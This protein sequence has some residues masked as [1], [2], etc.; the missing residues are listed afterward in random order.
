MKKP[1]NL[2]AGDKFR[3]IEE[4]TGFNVGEIVSLKEDD[5]SDWPY[6]WKADKSDYHCIFFSQLEPHTKTIRDAQ[7]GDEVEDSNAARYLVFERGQSTVLLS[8]KNDFT[9]TGDSYIF[10]QLDRYFTLKAEP[11]VDDKTAEAMKLLKEAGY[12]ISKDSL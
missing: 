5:G 10:D 8:R 6:F 1:T 12:K 4:C 2:K 3:V 11:V 7:V 9:K